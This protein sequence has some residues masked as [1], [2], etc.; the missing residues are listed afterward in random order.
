MTAAAFSN[1]GSVLA[2]A[3]E[4]VITLWDPEKNVLVAVI[5]GGAPPGPHYPPSLAVIGSTREPIEN[6][7]FIRD[8]NFLVST[9]QGS[10]PQLSVWSM[11]KLSV[12]WS[13]KLHTEA[14][15]CSEKD[16]HFAVLVVLP[17]SSK[18]DVATSHSGAILLFNAGDTVP[19]A[20]WFVAKAKGGGIAFIQRSRSLDDDMDENA[21]QVL[22]AYVNGEHEYAV[23]N[24]HG[25]EMQERKVRHT[26]NVPMSASGPEVTGQIGYASI[27][28]K[29]PEFKLEAIEARAENATP[30]ER[31]WETIFSGP[32]H[33]LPPLTKY[34]LS[35]IKMKWS[36]VRRQFSPLIHINGQF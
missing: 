3:A 34:N 29:L 27:Y 9:S 19:V 36:G 2:I 13:Y 16:S 30:S 6:L 22:L 4:T 10:N 26:D 31:P 35:K 5:S 18:A 33:S 24:P 8:S 11:S 21:G 32:S 14:I 12:S 1:D 23:F 7:S 17:E 28:G 15:A 20:S 25:V